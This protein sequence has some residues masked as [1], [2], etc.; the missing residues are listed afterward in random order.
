MSGEKEE[1]GREELSPPKVPCKHCFHEIQSST[2]FWT[3]KW[4]AEEGRLYET[5]SS[6]RVCCWCGDS[7]W[8]HAAS[9][10]PYTRDHPARYLISAG[11][12]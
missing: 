8:I 3:S 7:S 5:Q 2:L 6:L 10:G 12:Y 11:H 1:I 9:E 4:R